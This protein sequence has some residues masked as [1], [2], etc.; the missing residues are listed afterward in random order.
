MLVGSCAQ[1]RR[2]L[3]RNTSWK[4]LHSMDS[5]TADTLHSD[6]PGLVTNSGPDLRL[7]DRPASKF[8]WDAIPTLVFLLTSLF[9]PLTDLP[10]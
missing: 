6:W 7:V 4:A 2:K 3:R 5:S 1:V 10:L 8:V 9:S